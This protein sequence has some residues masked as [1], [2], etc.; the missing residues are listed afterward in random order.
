MTSATKGV[1]YQYQ[2]AAIRSLG[3]LRTPVV[4]GKETMS[5]LGYRTPSIQDQARASVALD[6]REDRPLIGNA[7]RTGQ[8]EVAITALLERQEQRLDESAL[9][10]GIEKV[11][12]S[13]TMAAGSASRTLS[14]RSVRNWETI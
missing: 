11:I 9:K 3:D 13:G 5:F 14:S 1:K 4:G 2:V 12:A 10:W 6:Q 8:F 7:R